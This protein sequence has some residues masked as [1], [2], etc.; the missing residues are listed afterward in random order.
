M[1]APGLAQQLALMDNTRPLGAGEHCAALQQDAAL[2][3]KLASALLLAL[4]R[5][6]ADIAASDPPTM[7]SY[8]GTPWL[9]RALCSQLLRQACKQQLGGER[10]AASLESAAQLVLC[11]PPNFGGL[12]DT[13]EQHLEAHSQLAALLCAACKA[14]LGPV[15]QGSRIAAG[16]MQQLLPQLLRR[17]GSLLRLGERVTASSP[18]LL[19]QIC[20]NWAVILGSCGVAL[21]R[22]CPPP[23]SGP[24]AA[25]EQPSGPQR[26]TAPL[27]D[28]Q[29]N[30][31]AYAAAAAALRLLPQLLDASQALTAAA[32]GMAFEEERHREIMCEVAETVGLACL[33]LADAVHA[34]LLATVEHPQ[35]HTWP[36]V[37]LPMW[38]LHA[39]ACR[40]LHWAQSGGEADQQRRVQLLPLLGQEHFWLTVAGLLGG[41]MSAAAA[42][43]GEATIYQ[44][45]YD[46][47]SSL[48][49]QL[50]G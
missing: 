10:G 15:G 27:A 2:C 42:G 35:A 23:A 12:E 46:P 24:A 6:A 44:C 39:A 18:M 40:L 43:L 41:L 32:A 31:V 47:N 37:Q 45:Q 8:A 7:D 49:E 5:R 36:E 4:Q 17:L 20:S 30:A 3:S 19:I 38:Q 16:R 33:C 50:A 22:T 21:K 1:A 25:G 26:G 34:H 11:T 48:V 13:L 14:Q 9:V 28:A 29:Q